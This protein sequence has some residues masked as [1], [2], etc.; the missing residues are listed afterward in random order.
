MSG[1]RDHCGIKTEE[2]AAQCPDNRASP[3]VGVQ[4][5]V[6]FCADNRLMRT[7]LAREPDL[8]RSNFVGPGW[9]DNAVALHR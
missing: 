8:H 6:L 3:Q 1:A 4:G 5:R 9:D 7:F 2:Q